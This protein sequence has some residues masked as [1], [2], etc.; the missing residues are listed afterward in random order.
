[1]K[2]LAIKRLFDNS[3]TAADEQNKTE[4]Y[5]LAKEALGNE[6][7][8]YD[9]NIEINIVADKTISVKNR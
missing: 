9:L 3:R 8:D 4:L 5:K 6:L 2:D 1:M 7:D